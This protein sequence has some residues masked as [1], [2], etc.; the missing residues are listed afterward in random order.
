M[1]TMY[2]RM[3]SALIVVGLAL[4]IALVVPSQS[5]AVSEPGGSIYIPMVMKGYPGN[6]GVEIIAHDTVYA[7]N[8]VTVTLVLRDER[9][10][11]SASVCLIS[12]AG[13][14][15]PEW[16]NPGKLL[17]PCQ[18]S[19][20]YAGVVCYDCQAPDG[21]HVGGDLFSVVFWARVIGPTRLEARAFAGYDDGYGRVFADTRPMTVTVR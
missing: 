15:W 7:N 14:L 21:Q 6:D 16:V 5:S 19:A 13:F 12:N 2:R 20:L 17:Q 11:R 8:L 18:V 10:L 9:P 4:A 3:H 1:V